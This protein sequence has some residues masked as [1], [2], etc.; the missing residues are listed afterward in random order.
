M[1]EEP[2]DEMARIAALQ[3]AFDTDNVDVFALVRTWKANVADETTRVNGEA[4]EAWWDRNKGK[5]T[6][7]PHPRPWILVESLGDGEKWVKSDLTVIWSIAVE[8]DRE[9]WLH[10]SVSRVPHA[11]KDGTRGVIAAV[12]LPSYEDLKQAKALFIGESRYAYSVWPPAVKHVNIHQGVL[13]LFS[14]LTG[15]W[16]DGM[17]LP[18]FTRGLGTI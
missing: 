4:H 1:G 18:D 2:M 8:T 3:A 16:D 6:L 5:Q 11:F 12:V 9:A 13:H 14:R 17:S 15:E 7:M 10:L